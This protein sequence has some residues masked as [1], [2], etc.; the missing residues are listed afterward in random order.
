[1]RMPESRSISRCEVCDGHTLIPVLDLGD[2]PMCDD[3]IP[4][5]NNAEPTRYPLQLVACPNCLTVHQ[6]YQVPKATLFPQ[7]YHYRAAMTEDVLSGMRELVDLVEQ[8]IGNLA[9]K[10]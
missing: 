4:I 9:G 1:M 8:N 6:K 7:T 2:Q 10:Q 3:L 5:G